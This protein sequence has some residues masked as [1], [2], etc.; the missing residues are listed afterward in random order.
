MC[1]SYSTGKTNFANEHRGSCQP[2]F[3]LQVAEIVLPICNKMVGLALFT[4][5]RLGQPI[6]NYGVAKLYP[7]LVKIASQTV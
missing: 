7:V 2:T 6:N 5:R 3:V 4:E 1:F